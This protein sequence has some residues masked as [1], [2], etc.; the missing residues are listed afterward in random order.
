ML[1][2][3]GILSTVVGETDALSDL[4]IGRGYAQGRFVVL[5]DDATRYEEAGRLLADLDAHPAR[6]DP[7]WE[8]DAS[9][10]DLSRLDPDLPIPCPFC[11]YDLRGQT[12]TAGRVTC[13]ECGRE[14][15]ALE[16]ILERHGPEALEGCYPAPADPLPDAVV[17]ALPLF[18]RRCRYPLAGLPRESHCP[19]CGLPY[20]KRR[21]LR[22]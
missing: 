9:T 11:T 7:G 2:A 12:R 8:E 14:V 5:L 19:E 4:G 17:D 18:C 20:S 21:M 13:P 22:R 16:A 15:N 1:R 3:A 10:P 6:A